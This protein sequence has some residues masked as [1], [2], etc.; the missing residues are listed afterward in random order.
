MNIVTIKNGP[1]LKKSTLKTKTM[2]F[3]MPMPLW[4]KFQKLCWD[5]S[6]GCAEVMRNLI[7]TYVDVDN[8]KKAKPIGNNELTDGSSF[9]SLLSRK[10]YCGHIRSGVCG[11]T[12]T[13]IM[14]ASTQEFMVV[15]NNKIYSMVGDANGC[16]KCID[17]L[18]D[19]ALEKLHAV[20]DKDSI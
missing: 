16:P 5:K 12:H 4:R 10:V 1:K 18:R 19:E 13:S 20:A 3:R 7:S 17:K 15:R 2:N 6:L 11:H 9:E 14:G 8:G